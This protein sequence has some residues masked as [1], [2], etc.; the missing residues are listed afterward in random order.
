M[1]GFELMSW[2]LMKCQDG[3]D[4][5]VIDEKT[6]DNP[7]VMYNRLLKDLGVHITTVHLQY[8]AA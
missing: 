1:L 8:S 5:L 4:D 6:V 7:A 3:V 2:S